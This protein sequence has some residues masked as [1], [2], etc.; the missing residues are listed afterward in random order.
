MTVVTRNLA[1][2]TELA[3]EMGINE[4]MEERLERIRDVEW[5]RNLERN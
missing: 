4:E 5:D 3:R 1:P 2:L